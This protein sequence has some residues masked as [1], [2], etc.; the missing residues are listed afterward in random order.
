MEVSGSVVSSC[1]LETGAFVSLNGTP[2]LTWMTG[3]ERKLV[4]KATRSWRDRC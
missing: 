4:R 1:D 2:L 3:D